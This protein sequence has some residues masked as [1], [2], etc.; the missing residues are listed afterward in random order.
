VRVRVRVRVRVAVSGRVSVTVR[1][2]VRVGVKVRVRSPNP[3][4]GRLPLIN[5]PLLLLN[6]YDD[7]I[8]PGASLVDA[9]A[10]ARVNEH[11][12]MALTSHGS[13]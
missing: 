4:L 9:V 5:T 13:G 10:H 8:V 3:T 12:V 6:A 7:P 1:V 11:I 2:R